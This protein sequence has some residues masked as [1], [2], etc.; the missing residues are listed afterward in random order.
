MLRGGDVKEIQ[1]FHRQGLSIT[2]I[3]Q[4]TGYSRDTIRKYLETTGIP[5]YG[6]RPPRP[7]KLDP[8]IPFLEERLKAGVWNAVVLFRELKE[9]GYDGSYTR[10][11]AYL[12]PRRE[13]AWTAVVRR[14]ETP[15]GQQAQVDWGEIGYLETDA[16]RKRLSCFVLTLGHSRAMFCDIALDQTL[17]TLLRMHEAAFSAL[18][19]LPRE[20]LYDR[21]KTVVLGTDERGET[22]WHPTFLDFS[23]YWGYTPRLCRPYRPQTK[24]KTESGVGYVKKSFLPGRQAADLEALRSQQRDW[25]WNVANARVHGTTFRVVY[26]AWEE[27]KPALGVVDGRPPYPLETTVTRKVARDAYVSYR[28]S[29]YSVPWTSVGQDVQIRE[30]D[31]Q[32]EIYRQAERIADHRVSA[33]KHQVITEPVHHEGI[34]S[35]GTAARRKPKIVLR[36]AAPEVEV[37]DLAVYDRIG[38]GA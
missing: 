35:A 6:P 3:Q 4:L 11:K 29:R 38:D 30:S 34:P 32:L 14:F 7:T 31:G 21:M 5:R 1:E 8:F 13:A 12:H 26:E 15:P 18:G 23:G 20:I 37:R 22:R 28:A 36:P 27:E 2:Q 10:V 33:A 19:G 9:R 16:G 24:G 25:L 17:E